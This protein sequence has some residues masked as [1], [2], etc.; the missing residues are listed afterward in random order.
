MAVIFRPRG[1]YGTRTIFCGAST[2]PTRLTFLNSF[3][4]HYGENMGGSHTRRSMA[5]CKNTKSNIATR[6]ML[7]GVRSSSPIIVPPV[8]RMN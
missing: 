5:I 3:N 6:S 2:G 1:K 8:K 7:S 4:R